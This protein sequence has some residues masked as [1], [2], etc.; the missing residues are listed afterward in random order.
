[1]E[2][3]PAV[4]F[5]GISAKKTAQ[6]KFFG[7]SK[8]T[9]DSADARGYSTSIGWARCC[10]HAGI[11]CIDQEQPVGYVSIANEFS[12]TLAHF[13]AAAAEALVTRTRPSLR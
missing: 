5:V 7:A 13:Q 2:I 3:S 8:K 10:G 12:L 11:V 6:E 4:R 9:F 1:V